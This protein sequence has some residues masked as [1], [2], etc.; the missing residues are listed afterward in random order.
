LNW[1]VFFG[2]VG[3]WLDQ[4]DG[5]LFIILEVPFIT[6]EVMFIRL[7][8]VKLFAAFTL[9]FILVDL[10]TPGHSWGSSDVC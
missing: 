1:E 10:E 9:C 2:Y 6:L 5:I 3:A 4:W 8:N 7:H